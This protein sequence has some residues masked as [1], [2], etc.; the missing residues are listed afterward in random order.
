MQK[1]KKK[2]FDIALYDLQYIFN[3]I[4]KVGKINRF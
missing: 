1:K 2:V 4:T 3:L